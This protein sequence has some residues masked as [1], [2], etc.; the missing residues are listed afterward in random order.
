MRKARGVSLRV[1]LLVASALVLLLARRTGAHD[2]ADDD[3]EFEASPASPPEQPK[4]TV[5]SAPQPSSAGHTHGGVKPGTGHHH[6]DEEEFDHAPSDKGTP[7]A[8]R[9]KG[10][11]GG[12][13][14]RDQP[15]SR[16]MRPRP[17]KTP[18][19]FIPE[20]LAGM[21]FVFYLV[22]MY[23]G[24]NYNKKIAIAWF[25]ENVETLEKS[26]AIVGFGKD[27][28]EGPYIRQESWDEYL[29]YASGRQG[30]SHLLA[31]L[32]LDRRQD[33]VHSFILK[34]ITPR[35]DTCIIEIPFDSMDT[36]VMAVLRRKDQK[37][38]HN[39][40]EDLKEFAKARKSD[41]P[42]S[43]V[44]LADS[45]DPVDHLLTPQ[46]VKALTAF[47][48]SLVCLHISDIHG[49]IK[50]PT[51]GGSGGGGASGSSSSA[52][53]E[54]TTT[55][56]SSEP[57]G[58]DSRYTQP[59]QRGLR[60]EYRLPDPN[61]MTD[62]ADL[63]R[64]ALYLIEPAS[65]LR[66]SEKSR[67]TVNDARREVERAQFK[68]SEA[69]RQEKIQKRK[70]EKKKQEEEEFEKLTPEQQR[71]REEKNHKKSLKQRQPKF[72]MIRM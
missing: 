51:S 57:E 23:F 25:E 70:L 65:A 29:F 55:T 39:K 1:L 60:L 28:K 19:D 58:K 21:L 9:G 17:R 7:W 40:Y 35:P 33:A 15:P 30:C 37:I 2:L 22:H 54:S 27:P 38:I 44:V 42:Q 5:P 4:S 49:G 56:A 6:E 32:Q 67:S 72:K 20:L 34:Y 31:R 41:L 16:T 63:L 10:A 71:K 8:N 52:S 68:E 12:K 47:E 18:E 13:Q 36:Y 43:L 11:G 53:A 3:E 64:L 69:E 26:F 62:F 66:I 48:S 14:R 50:L 61:K 46:V 24:K 45:G 59:V